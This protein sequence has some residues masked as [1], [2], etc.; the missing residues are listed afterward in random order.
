MIAANDPRLS[1]V[2]LVMPF[3][4]GAADAA[5]FPRGTLE[6]AWKDRAATAKAWTEKK[7]KL[8]TTHVQLWNT[9]LA[10]AE[11]TGPQPFLAGPVPYN[12]I[13]EARKKSPRPALHLLT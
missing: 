11:G 1:A 7:Q 12:F 8:P 13:T 5:A 10:E 3:T 4:S 9:S 6:K 2:I